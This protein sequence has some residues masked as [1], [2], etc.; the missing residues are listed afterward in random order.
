MRICAR[1][2]QIGWSASPPGHRTAGV[3]DVSTE[4]T[5]S[6]SQPWHA[7]DGVVLSHVVALPCPRNVHAG[8]AIDRP[9]TAMAASLRYLGLPGNVCNRLAVLPS[10][11]AYPYQLG[12]VA[13]PVE[14]SACGVENLAVTTH[15]VSLTCVRRS[16]Y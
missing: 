6:A 10:R 1:E 11:R 4:Y 16:R 2:R 15:C 14:Q 5:L 9:S 12:F 7:D 8:L 3:P 13:A